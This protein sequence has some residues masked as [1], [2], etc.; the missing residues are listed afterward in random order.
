MCARARARRRDQQLARKHLHTHTHALFSFLVWR[1]AE[2]FMSL[3]PVPPPPTPS[4]P[5]LSR[6]RVDN[7]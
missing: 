4:V 6:R 5:P 3:L 7:T 1:T 2:P